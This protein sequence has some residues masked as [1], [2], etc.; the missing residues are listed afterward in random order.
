VTVDAGCERLLGDWLELPGRE[1]TTRDSLLVS[2]EL[3]VS[4]R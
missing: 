4:P 1:L 2:G 3:V